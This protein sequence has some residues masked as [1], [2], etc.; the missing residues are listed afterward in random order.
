MTEQIRRKR[1][2]SDV[3]IRTVEGRNTVV[4]IRIEHSDDGSWTVT[5]GTKLGA[6]F[7]GSEGIPLTVDDAVER[8]TAE[9]DRRV[10]PE[11]AELVSAS[12]VAATGGSIDETLLGRSILRR[13]L[14]GG[15]RAAVVV[16][17]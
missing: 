12:I 9:I 15:D 11:D 14:N 2:D 3:E 1:F 17:R 4:S 16:T 13:L 8:V 7:V 6:S 10:L 5:G